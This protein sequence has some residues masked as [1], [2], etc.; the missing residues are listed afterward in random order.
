MRSLR[1]PSA[2]TVVTMLLAHSANALAQA[3]PREIG[4]VVTAR[5]LELHVPTVAIAMVRDGAIESD[6]LL[7][8][9]AYV[10]RHDA[11]FEAASLSKPVFAAIVVRLATAGRIDL[12]APLARYASW[13][14]FD[15]PRAK[16]ITARMILSHTSGLRNATTD[17]HTPL[18][19]DPGTK[20]LYSGDGYRRLQRVVEQITGEPLKR[21]A[22]EMMFEPLGMRRTTFADSSGPT[23]NWATGHDRAGRALPVHTFARASASTSLRTTAEDYA[24]FLITVLDASHTPVTAEVRSAM[25]RPTALVDSSLDLHWGLGWALQG[26]AFFH[27]GSDPGFK[28]FVFGDRARHVGIVMLTDGDNGLEIAPL[29]ARLVTGRDYSFFRFY[30]LHPTD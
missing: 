2:L 23:A 14:A 10:P 30:L 28:S 7:S 5:M 3:G 20:W 4:R 1:I 27:W 24:R 8:L 13:P 25:L 6:T 26:D 19:S 21:L 29:L 22:A 9:D 17:L 12:D 16:A 18:A 15:D 11:L